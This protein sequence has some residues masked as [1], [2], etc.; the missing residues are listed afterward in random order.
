MKN[1]LQNG[2][3]IRQNPNTVLKS[4][5]DKSRFFK[6]EG[7]INSGCNKGLKN[8]S[9][10]DHGRKVFIFLFGGSELDFLVVVVSVVLPS[11]SSL[12]SSSSSL[13]WD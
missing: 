11:S 4:L 3:K 13:T 10:A 8:E 12:S 7:N 6:E 5:A 1:N 9:S 2:N